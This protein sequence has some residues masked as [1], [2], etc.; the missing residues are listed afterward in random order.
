MRLFL[1]SHDGYKPHEL[2]VSK[3]PLELKSEESI[4]SEITYIALSSYKQQE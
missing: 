4:F 3:I 1:S 2:H